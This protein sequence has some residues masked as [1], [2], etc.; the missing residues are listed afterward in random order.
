MEYNN[1]ELS[2]IALGLFS[3]LGMFL[4]LPTH[5]KLEKQQEATDMMRITENKRRARWTFAE[6][7]HDI[8]CR[9]AFVV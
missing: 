4:V 7:I 3:R 5:I 9:G 8:Y 6:G 2:L 1:N